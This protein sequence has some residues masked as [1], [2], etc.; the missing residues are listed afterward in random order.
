MFEISNS[1]LC[2]H[3][4]G[5]LLGGGGEGGLGGGGGVA[6]VLKEARLGLSSQRTDSSGTGTS[7][8]KKAHPKFVLPLSFLVSVGL[9]HCEAV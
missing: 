2:L 1:W 4:K 7:S 5:V 3:P 8:V 9:C 6:V